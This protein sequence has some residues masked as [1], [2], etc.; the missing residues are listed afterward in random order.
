[1][2][3]RFVFYKYP[4]DLEDDLMSA[5][6][7]SNDLKLFLERFYNGPKTMTVDEVYNIVSG[8]QEMH[9]L[10]SQRAWDT[11]EGLTKTFYKL[12]KGEKPEG[13][14]EY[15]QDDGLPEW[16]G[17]PPPKENP[18]SE[19]DTLKAE[20]KRLKGLLEARVE[21]AATLAETAGLEA[22]MTVGGPSFREKI[23]KEIRKLKKKS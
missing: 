20:I 10:R 3:N 6:N 12:Q 22:S 5:W 9:E 11:F 18:V 13:S 19:V 15:E 16:K 17:D 4:V 7:T 23:A 8:I 14:G 1:M 2:I 21:E